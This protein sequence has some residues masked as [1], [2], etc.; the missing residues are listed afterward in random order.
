MFL[1]GISGEPFS[2]KLCSF[3]FLCF[4]RGLSSYKHKKILQSFDEGIAS[5]G[6]FCDVR[7][8]KLSFS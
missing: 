7:G 5:H 8:A 2:F 4:A 1:L 6:F 3:A